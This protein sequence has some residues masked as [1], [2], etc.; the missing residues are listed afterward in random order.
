[1][2]NDYKYDGSGYSSS[3][4]DL[5]VLA[6]AVSAAFAYMSIMQTCANTGTDLNQTRSETR[7]SQRLVRVVLCVA[8]DE[9]SVNIIRRRIS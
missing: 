9:N 5:N 6:S 4:E 2:D 8:K 3:S 1:M 7:G